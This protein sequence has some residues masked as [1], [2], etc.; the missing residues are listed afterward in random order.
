MPDT[1]ITSLSSSANSISN[2]S[3]LN[4]NYDIVWSFEFVLSGNAG[5]QGSFTTFLYDNNT[6]TGGGA[7]LG[8]GYAPLSSVVLGDLYW[9]TINDDQDDY[10]EYQNDTWQS[11]ATAVK[12]H[13]NGSTYYDYEGYGG[14]SPGDNIGF[15]KFVDGDNVDILSI[16]IFELTTT[17]EDISSTI[18][19][20]SALSANFAGIEFTPV[21]DQSPVY[22]KFDS[23]M[24]GLSAEASLPSSTGTSPLVRRNLNTYEGVSGAAIGI[25]FDTTGL[26]ALSSSSDIGGITD[27]VENS[28]SI[29]SGESTNY[30]LL[31]STPLSSLDSSFYL[32]SDENAFQTLRFRLTD[33]GQTIKIDVL[34]DGIYNEI[35][36]YPINLQI[37]DN[38]QYKVGISYTS[39]V[40]GRDS[41]PYKFSI[42]NFHIDGVSATPDSNTVT[43]NNND[44]EQYSLSGFNNVTAPTAAVTIVNLESI[45]LYDCPTTSLSSISSARCVSNFNTTSATDTL[46][47][48][49]IQAVG[50]FTNVTSAK[51]VPVVVDDPVVRSNRNYNCSQ[52]VTER[53]YQ[54][55]LELSLASFPYIDTINLTDT[56]DTVRFDYNFKTFGGKIEIYYDG[57]EVIDTGYVLNDID[58]NET[59]FREGLITVSQDDASS[60]TIT[61]NV[62]GTLT[63]NKSTTTPTSAEVRIYAPLSG[64]SYEYTVFCPILSCG[65]LATGGQTADINAA[66]IEGYTSSRRV[67]DLGEDTGTV[68]LAYSAWDLP[69]RYQVYY[70]GSLVIDT[71]WVGNSAQKFTD[72]LGSFLT[73]TLGTSADATTILPGSGED[74][75]EKTTTS[76]TTA[77]VVVTSPFYGT[78]WNYR[79]RCPG[80][81]YLPAF[82]PQSFI[83]DHTETFP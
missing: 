11:F 36:S 64:T 67:V 2:I 52:A 27:T 81:L 19:A 83:L 74:T 79:L 14:Y 63:F 71:L 26:F 10:S 82:I 41:T 58:S 18:Q 78:V 62:S 3:Y 7:S 80:S 77:E 32:T 53:T 31:T 5:D 22:F 12:D 39:P 50:S 55:P 42:K 20:N 13:F 33:I 56:T 16:D 45:P 43:G 73:N 40:S 69:D 44:F 72:M 15:I 30:S 23:D 9:S 29:R 8:G 60:A 28:L 61:D 38:T 51:K 70:D 24:D 57:A 34:R 68:T 17:M 47:L 35:L 54:T 1:I 75:F 25:N 6:L 76:P 59:R 37:D 65:E 66:G 49:S 21:D 48:P 46:I 4:A